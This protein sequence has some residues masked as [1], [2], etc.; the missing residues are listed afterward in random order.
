LQLDKEKE[1]QVS[2]QEEFKRKEDEK[3]NLNSVNV[4]FEEKGIKR[5]ATL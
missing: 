2:L 5:K 1:K 4:V 3:A